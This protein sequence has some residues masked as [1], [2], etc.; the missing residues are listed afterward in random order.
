L[1]KDSFEQHVLQ[2]LPAKSFKPLINSAVGVSL[3][4]DR[5]LVSNCSSK[6]Y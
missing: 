2:T 6:L 4:I 5:P 3:N 1:S